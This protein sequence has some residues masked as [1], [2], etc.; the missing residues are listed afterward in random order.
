M[1]T[2]VKVTTS[3][4]ALVVASLVALSPAAAQYRVNYGY[5]APQQEPNGPSLTPYGGYMS[6]GQYEYGKLGSSAGGGGGAMV[7]AQ[8]MLPLSEN[9]AILGNV[10][11][12]N[13][14]FSFNDLPPFTCPPAPAACTGSPTVGSTGMWLYD[15]DIQLSAPFRGAGGHW[16]D[17]F[18]QVGAG[19]MQYTT[20][21]S[22]VSLSST[23]F[24]FN[25]G[26]GLDYAF[27]KGVGLRILIKDYVGQW[28]TTPAN[29]PGQPGTR[30]TNN[31]AY[32]GGLKLTF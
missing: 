11:H 28:S 24:A 18:I 21:S 13:S 7:G 6:L 26:A 22:T 30:Y 23:N 12:V 14:D 32:T 25:G 1:N 17:P 10:A 16:V 3:L 29:T 4:A 5:S 20:Q 31:L 8:F 15:G 9:V 2:H 27:S 19:E